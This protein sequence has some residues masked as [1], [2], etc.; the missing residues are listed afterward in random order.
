MSVSEDF[1]PF[2]DIEQPAASN[3]VP[4]R[5]DA[6][7]QSGA[8]PV[9]F[10]AMPFVWRDPATIPRRKYLY[11]YE[12][13][14]KQVSGV[15]A[16]GAAG[17]TTLKVGRAL[18]MV[19]GRDLLGHRVWNG[20]HRVWLW[21]LE[22]EMEEVEKTVHA[23]VKLWNLDPA[24]LKDRLFIN[25]MDS[26]ATSQLK[27]AVDD[28]RGRFTIQ[29]PIATAVVAEL[30]AMGI[31]YLDVDPF[32]SSHGVDENNNSAIDAV[33]KEWVRIAFEANCAISLAHHVRKPSGGETSAHDARG[34]SA[35]VNAARSVLVLQRMSVDDAKGFRVPE[36]D[37]RKYF[38]VYDDKNNKAPS[39]SQA[40][41][42]E[43]VGMG[44]GNGDDT[45]PEDNIGAAHRWYP[46]DTFEGVNGSQLQYIQKKIAAAPKDE[47]RKSHLSPG[48]VGKIVLAVLGLNRDDPGDRERVKRMLTA[49]IENGALRT[50]DLADKTGQK[51]EH[52]EVGTWATT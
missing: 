7:S 31:D 29:R 25:G 40:E 52:V 20:P 21:N 16:P 44:L 50:V 47:C 19:T 6:R 32:V 9:I 26:P 1:D 45:G 13:R 28:Q 46:P 4:L 24:D 49:W 22:D 2:A 17:K 42:Y 39:A 36:C 37:R 5:D 27:L 10:R 43:F 18:C 15:V 11:G 34:A 41:W 23:Y 12:L 35:M 3:V 51:R 48:W 33:A 8:G 30:I 38:S 14:R